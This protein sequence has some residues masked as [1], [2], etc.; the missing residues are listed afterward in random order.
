MLANHVHNT[1]CPKT[2]TAVVKAEHTAAGLE[3]R[4]TL[5]CTESEIMQASVDKESLPTYLL[6]EASELSR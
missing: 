1:S 6:A 4:Y 2:S 3:K 5:S